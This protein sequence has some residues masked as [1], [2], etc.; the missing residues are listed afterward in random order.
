TLEAE[1]RAL[2]ARMHEPDYYRQPPDV[3]RADRERTDEIERLL[4]EKLERWEALEGK[5]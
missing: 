1:Q 4:M 2:Y 5:H 3:L